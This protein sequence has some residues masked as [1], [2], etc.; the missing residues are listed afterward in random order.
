MSNGV[1]TILGLASRSEPGMLASTDE[2]IQYNLSGLR[3]V[4]KFTAS[5]E[6]EHPL[7]KSRS[8]EEVLRSNLLRPLSNSKSATGQP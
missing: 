7:D 5:D 8:A 4:G 1:D 2:D 6:L 3:A